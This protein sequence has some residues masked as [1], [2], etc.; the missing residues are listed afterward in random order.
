MATAI[1]F[2]NSKD[3][4]LLE[5]EEILFIEENMNLFVSPISS[6]YKRKME[7]IKET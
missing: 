7:T 4:F 5:T 6:C 3:C 2:E 1:K